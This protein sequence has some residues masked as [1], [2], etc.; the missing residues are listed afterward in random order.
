ML[1]L[2]KEEEN[3]WATNTL[4]LMYNYMLPKLSTSPMSFSKTAINLASY[5]QYNDFSPPTIS[6]VLK[7]NNA[8]A[9]HCFNKYIFHLYY[10][11]KKNVKVLD[12]FQLVNNPAYLHYSAIG[13]K[14]DKQDSNQ[15][16][17]AAKGNYPTNSTIRHIQT[18]SISPFNVNNS[19]RHTEFTIQK[20]LYQ[21]N[22]TL[23]YNCV[24]DITGRLYSKTFSKNQSKKSN[25]RKQKWIN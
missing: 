17:L 8:Y 25:P 4:V 2:I 3:Q 21:N 12:S 22:C 9:M 11:Y 20:Q 13:L 24:P 5:V 16:Y 19:Y 18:D 7:L 23:L 1:C 15:L 14:R 6:A 10:I